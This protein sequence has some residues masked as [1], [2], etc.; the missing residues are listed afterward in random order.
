MLPTANSIK[1]K[2]CFR[3]VVIDQRHGCLSATDQSVRLGFPLLKEQQH[4]TETFY[5]HKMSNKLA[6]VQ[7]FLENRSE[8]ETPK[9]VSLFYSE[10]VP[11]NIF[12]IYI[13]FVT[14]RT[15]Q[16]VGLARCP[17]GLQL[18]RTF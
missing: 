18:S 9:H 5:W 1:R 12:P 6:Q 3:T 15:I 14:K 17:H 11:H 4:H 16:V 8:L 10:Y 7:N 13:D 2:N